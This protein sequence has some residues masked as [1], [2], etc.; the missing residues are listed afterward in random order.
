KES[1][2]VAPEGITAGEAETIKRDVVGKGGDRAVVYEPIPFVPIIFAGV[3]FTVIAGISS[4]HY[5]KLL[6]FR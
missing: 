6:V 2:R 3:I 4:V 1:L 5:V